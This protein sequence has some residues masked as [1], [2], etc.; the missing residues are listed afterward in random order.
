[1]RAALLIGIKYIKQIIL[2]KFAYV[3]G[4]IQVYEPCHCVVE[5]F[6][7]YLITELI[8]FCSTGLFCFF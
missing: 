8:R 5:Q 7:C 2:I 1:M 6:Y 4:L 3:K